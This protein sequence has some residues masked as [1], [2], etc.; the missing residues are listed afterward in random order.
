MNVDKD[1]EKLEPTGS[2]ASADATL[3][4]S[5]ESAPTLSTRS[6][7]LIPYVAASRNVP[8]FTLRA[9]VLGII[10]GIVFGAANSFLGL[11]TGLTV[12]A[13]IP[14]AVMSMAILRGVF[15]TGTVLENNIVQ[16]LGSTGESLAAGVIFTV[17]ALVFLGMELPSLTF[18]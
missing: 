17:P 13:S 8:E 7:D 1:E 14:A 6:E 2:A 11:K 16:T 10:I 18:S 4:K 3:S 9:M 5:G 12:T 15:K